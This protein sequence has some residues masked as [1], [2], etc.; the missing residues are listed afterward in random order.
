MKEMRGSL[1]S[2]AMASPTSAPPLTIE[3]MAGGSELARRT[4]STILMMATWTK[5]VEGAPFL[6]VNEMSVN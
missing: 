5:G 3:Q 2:L 1:L 4:S 6:K